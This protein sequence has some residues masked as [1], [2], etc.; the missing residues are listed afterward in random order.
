MRNYKRKTTRGSTNKEVYDLAVQEALTSTR[1]YRDIAAEYNICH[2]TLFNYVKKAKTGLEY[3]VGYSKPRLI[4]NE[5]QERSIAEYL[6]KSASIYFGLL[7]EQVRSL[8][9]EAAV[10]QN[11]TI[12]ESW[13]KTKSAGIDWLKS[14][15]KRNPDLSI[16][17]PE[18][19]SLSR[20]TSFNRTNVHAFFEKYMDVLQ[21]YDLTP[22]RIWNM[23]ETGVTTVQK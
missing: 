7:P 5:Q 12:P 21:R 19:T 13:H 3:N 10:D 2:V 23:D 14:F 17:S 22:S 4:F 6:K 15:I 18:A 11:I 1:K 9:Y 16:R 8:A 20:S